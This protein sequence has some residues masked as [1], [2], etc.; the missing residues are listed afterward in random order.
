M[1]K[2][3]YKLNFLALEG[4]IPSNGVAQQQDCGTILILLRQD[5]F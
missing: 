1:L 4:K 5:A 2:M 3:G